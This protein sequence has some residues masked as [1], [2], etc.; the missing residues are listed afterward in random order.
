MK[1]ITNKM[2]DTLVLQL[3]QLTESPETTYTKRGDKYQA[4]IGNYHLSYAYGGVALHRI[5]NKHG[6]IEDVLSTGHVPKRDLW[7]RIKAYK[8]GLYEGAK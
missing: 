8:T 1:R 7:N 3:N 4:N 2:L 6:G 5:Q